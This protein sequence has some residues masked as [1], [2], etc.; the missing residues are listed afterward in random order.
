MDDKD[1][2]S[3]GYCGY[4]CGICAGKSSDIEKRRKMVEGWKKLFG[5]T[6]YT[7]ENVPIKSPCCGCKGDGE[8]A[9][10]SCQ[11]RACAMEKGIDFCADC[12]EFPCKKVAPLLASRDGLLLY[13]VRGKDISLK[14]YELSAKQ[15]ENMPEINKRLK[16]KGKLPD[17][18]DD[19]KD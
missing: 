2:N 11:A 9:D 1:I 18:I 13:C 7:E 16:E 10:K 15:F 14:E 19:L 3:K 17:W 4:K 6:C 8:I 12:E 5:H